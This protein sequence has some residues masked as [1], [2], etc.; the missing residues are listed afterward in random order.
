MAT[1]FVH[2]LS[3]QRIVDRGTAVV[4][5]FIIG[6]I[7]FKLAIQEL[8]KHYVLEKHVR[9]TRI[10]CVLVG[11]P[12]V[13]IDTQARIILLGISSNRIAVIGTLGMALVE[14]SLRVGKAKIVKWSILQR[15]RLFLLTTVTYSR[16]STSRGVQKQES[17]VNSP[18]GPSLSGMH[19]DFEVWRRQ[20]QAFHT[21]EL[22]ADMYAEYIAIGCSAPILFFYASHPH[23]PLLRQSESLRTEIDVVAWR[24]NQLY[25]LVFQVAVELVV[26][27]MS[28]LLEMVIGIEFD[29]VKH[30]G[31]F[32]AALFMVTAVMN[33]TISVCIYLS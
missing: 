32:L 25:M 13:L 3:R 7:A 10:M 12:T 29:H 14:I 31:S 2:V 8:A 33:S 17:G 11:I 20:V 26:D 23:Y 5:G 16:Q 30:L 6:S 18:S 24:T 19:V 4:T 9:S 15:E 22:N 28:I 1:A 21:A 27:Y